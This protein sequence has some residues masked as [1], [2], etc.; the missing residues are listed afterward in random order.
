MGTKRRNR[1]QYDEGVAQLTNT[2]EKPRPS[3]PD[4]LPSF[5]MGGW[6]EGEGEGAPI[7]DA[8][9]GEPVT[10]LT[11]D[12][13][14]LAGALSYAREVGGPNLRKRTFHERAAMLK[15]IAKRLMA[16]K[17]RFYEV[18]F[19]TGTTRRDGWVDIEGGIGTLFAYSSLARREFPNETFLTEGDPIPLSK[20]GS[21]VGR[22]LLTP[23]EGVAV[24]I[25]AFNFPCWG[26]LEK[27]APTLLA[28]MPAVVKPAP[29]TAY[30]AEAMFREMLNTGLL[31]EGAV[32]LVAGDAVDFFSHLVEQ[33]VVTFTGSASTGKRLR[34]HP[35]C[36]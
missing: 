13:L 33:D 23:K 36:D 10:R 15:D 3:I 11:A 32:Q 29:Q 35:N 28:G 12:G 4:K 19:L 22:H 6:Q 17:E 5:V 25:N 26:M 8:V 1:L 30:L 21:F 18:S 2:L 7:L 31:P 9:Y 14:D 34:A 20:D 27:L 24:H 16:T